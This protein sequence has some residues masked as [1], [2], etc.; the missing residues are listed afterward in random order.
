MSVPTLRL[1]PTVCP[2]IMRRA[3]AQGASLAF[4][5]DLAARLYLREEQR[6][7]ALLARGHPR[8]AALHRCLVRR[9]GGL[10]G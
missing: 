6:A 3:L 7:D 5:Q 9:G 4:A 2:P 8:L 10:F 1:F